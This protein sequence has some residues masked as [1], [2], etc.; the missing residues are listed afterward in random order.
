MTLNI[1]LVY[2][3]NPQITGYL[4]AQLEPNIRLTSGEKSAHSGD[5]Q[6][7]VAGRPDRDIFV[8]NK[9]LHSLIVPWTGIPPETRELLIEFSHITIHNLHH[10]STPVAE[11]AVTLLLTAAKNVIPFDEALRRGDW[12]M[13]Y[14]KPAPSLIL[15]GKTV[16]ILG[17]GEIGRRVART[18]RSL[19]MNVLATKRNAFERDTDQ[20]PEEVH[21]PDKLHELLPLAQ[22]LVIALPLTKETEGLI[23]ERELGLMPSDSILVNIGRGLIVNEEALYQALKHGNIGAAGLDVWYNYPPE[24][25]SRSSTYPANYPFWELDNVV[26]SPHRAGLTKDID[27]RRMDHLAVLLNAAAKH[28][29]IPNNVDISI[30]Y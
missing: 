30:G 24:E 11:M 29:Q 28:E 15:K 13:R 8:A 3:Y 10:N 22:A 17:Y 6:I 7:L 19:G 14:Q 27:Y 1:H 2:E 23:G 20:F 25:E 26:M 16:L 9:D 18:C 12:T 5:I 21:P 4:N